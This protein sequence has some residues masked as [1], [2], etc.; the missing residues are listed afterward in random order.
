MFSSYSLRSWSPR[1]ASLA[2]MG[3]ITVYVTGA[4]YITVGRI[5]WFVLALVVGFGWL[6]I[7]ETVVLP[8]NAVRSLHQSVQAFS[9][10]AADTGAGVVDALN[11]ARDSTPSE[12]A[13]K[14]PRRHLELVRSCRSAI[15]RRF[16]GALVRGFSQR[17]VDQLARARLAGRSSRRISLVTHRSASASASGKT[18][19]ACGRSASGPEGSGEREPVWIVAVI[20]CRRMHQPSNS[21]VHAEVAVDLLDHSVGHFRS[22][23]QS[24]AAL[25]GLQF[26]EAG[27]DFPALCV[28][29]SKASLFGGSHAH[30]TEG[31]Q[32]YT[33]GK[34]V[35]SRWLDPSYGGVEVG[36]Q[37]NNSRSSQFPRLPETFSEYAVA[38]PSVHK[39]STERGGR[40]RVR[41]HDSDRRAATAGTCGLDRGGQPPDRRNRTDRSRPA[42][43]QCIG[44]R[45]AQHVIAAAD[46]G[47]INV[48][49]A[50]D[51]AV[52][53]FAAGDAHGGEYCRDGAGR[54]DC[55]G[56]S[57]VGRA[58]SAEHNST[59]GDTVNRDDAQARIVSLSPRGDVGVQVGQGASAR[60][61][62][63]KQRRPRER[64]RAR[65][66]SHCTADEGVHRGQPVMTGARG[67]DT[68]RVGRYR[69]FAYGSRRLVWRSWLDA[70][71][72]VGGDERAGRRAHENVHVTEIDA[73]GVLG[74]GEEA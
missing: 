62:T 3:A 54:R 52:D 47:H 55:I 37:Q 33:R 56:Q 49:D 35:T 9:R 16:P 11:T 27:L 30:G 8:D 40:A 29:P 60:G 31:V 46:G 43:R 53:V 22:Q 66:G 15:E 17:D 6:A 48:G 63:R 50:P 13:C 32:F 21:V 10:R 41:G 14:A 24:G 39:V 25:M 2:L 12:H 64:T 71:G 70:R 36:Y 68:Q 4:G 51:P 44:R 42:R 61:R 28:D 38:A 73:G 18:R 74:P 58:L 7:W 19:V 1:V 34:A 72:E 20:G 26:G 67:G 5:G 65:P 69:G 45:E 23:H 59:S 57:R